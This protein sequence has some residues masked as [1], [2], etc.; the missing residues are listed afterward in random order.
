MMD[1]YSRDDIRL[2]IDTD[3]PFTANTSHGVATYKLLT[4]IIIEV[5]ADRLRINGAG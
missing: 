1:K 3:T 4:R 5:M 2:N